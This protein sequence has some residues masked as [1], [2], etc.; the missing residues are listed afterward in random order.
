MI[1]Y[2]SVVSAMLLGSFL[3]GACSAQ[4]KPDINPFTGE[5]PDLSDPL[6]LLPDPIDN[7]KGEIISTTTEGFINPASEPMEPAV[8]YFL[9]LELK[10]R[11]NEVLCLVYPELSQTK[12]TSIPNHSQ[13]RIGRYWP[14]QTPLY[15]TRFD[16]VTLTSTQEISPDNYMQ[17]LAAWRG[18]PELTGDSIITCENGDTIDGIINIGEIHFIGYGE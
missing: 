7:V 5:P 6:I 15:L 3:L 16:M 10:S 8:R 11:D 9:T 2:K 14:L 4:K 12:E 18:D 13:V 1:S 17:K